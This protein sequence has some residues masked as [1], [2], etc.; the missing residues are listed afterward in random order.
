MRGD[1]SRVEGRHLKNQ[2]CAQH[3]QQISPLYLSV[4]SAAK[5]CD[6]SEKTIRRWIA[7]GLPVYQR[8][9][10]TKVLISPEDIR[11]FLTKRQSPKADLDQMVTEVARQLVTGNHN[12]PE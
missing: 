1:T 10:R 5:S 7:S 8:G 9:P 11:N 12:K 3:N 2:T 6:V 4:E